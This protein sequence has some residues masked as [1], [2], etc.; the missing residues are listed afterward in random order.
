VT[1]HKIAQTREAFWEQK[2]TQI[3]KDFKKRRL[4]WEDIRGGCGGGT[5]MDGS[6]VALSHELVELITDR[7]PNTWVGMML[8]PKARKYRCT[9]RL[10]PGGH[11]FWQKV[12]V[13]AVIAFSVDAQGSPN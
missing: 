12:S 4:R 5:F 1:R 3:S 7:V 9:E 13:N 6:T 11:A 2:R 10:H 8:V